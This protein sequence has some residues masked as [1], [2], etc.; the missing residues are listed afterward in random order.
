MSKDVCMHVCVHARV[1]ERVCLSDAREHTHVCVLVRSR[2]RACAFIIIFQL[3]I[4][5]IHIEYV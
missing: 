3:I 1:C 2:V 4:R 5:L